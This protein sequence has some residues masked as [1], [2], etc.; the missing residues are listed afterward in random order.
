MRTVTVTTA[1][2]CLKIRLEGR[3]YEGMTVKTG[4][5]TPHIPKNHGMGDNSRRK[6]YMKTGYQDIHGNST[7]SYAID[8]AA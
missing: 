6:F 3:T 7:N 5:V 8:H 2:W 4:R 1:C